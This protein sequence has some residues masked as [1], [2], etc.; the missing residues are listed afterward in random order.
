MSR[1]NLWYR[2][3]FERGALLK[4]GTT[5]P[6]SDPLP[7]IS[8][9]DKH[10]TLALSNNNRTVTKASGGNG[11]VSAR[12]V[13]SHT[14]GQKYV[15]VAFGPRTGNVIAGVADS[16]MDLGTYFGG[17][18]FSN[19]AGLAADGYRHA[20][21]GFADT[22]LGAVASGAVVAF[23]ID[24]DA[25]TMTAR[26]VT[27]GGTWLTPWTLPGPLQGAAALF[28]G[29]SINIQGDAVTVNTGG[30]A[31]VGAVPSGAVAWNV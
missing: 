20:G 4:G 10:S 14:T 27:T 1:F 9:T 8:P 12:S 26:N 30:A 15:E 2:H 23:L 16:N 7:A 18:L 3:R 21:T 25:N 11:W 5:A 17:D 29:V 24:L 22:G 31:F 28:F 19:S 13:T 6:P